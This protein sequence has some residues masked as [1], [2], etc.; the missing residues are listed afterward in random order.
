V[1]DR[2]LDAD[3]PRVSFAGQIDGNG[4]FVP[5]RREASTGTVPIS[6]AMAALLR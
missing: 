2:L 1:G 5:T 3:D 4:E 6:H